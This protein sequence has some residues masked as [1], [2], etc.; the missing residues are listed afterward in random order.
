MTVIRKAGCFSAGLF[1]IIFIPNRHP[2]LDSGPYYQ[3]EG[4]IHFFLRTK[5][6]LFKGE[7]PLV[8]LAT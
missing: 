2:E 8:A 7:L 5:V 1:F 6:F 4:F 3:P